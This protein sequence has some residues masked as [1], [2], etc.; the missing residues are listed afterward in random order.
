VGIR[1]SDEVSA[2][3]F[4]VEMNTEDRSIAVIQYAGY[5][6]PDFK[7]SKPKRTQHSIYIP[8]PLNLY[9]PE[10]RRPQRRLKWKINR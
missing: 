8:R 9:C 3:F 6:I 7:D 5:H 10:T 2:S 1:V 4:K